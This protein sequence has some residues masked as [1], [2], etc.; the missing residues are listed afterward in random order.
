MKK[1]VSIIVL[2]NM[3]LAAS[4]TAF[5]ESSLINTDEKLNAI[6]ETELPSG[7]KLQDLK[8][9]VE[10]TPVFTDGQLN[11]GS[12]VRYALDS[13]TL[14]DMSAYSSYEIVYESALPATTNY[15]YF[16]FGKYDSIATG[17]DPLAGQ[18]IGRSYTVAISPGNSSNFA[19]Y[20]FYK[21]V[22]VTTDTELSKKLSTDSVKYTLK[23]DLTKTENNISFYMDDELLFMDSDETPVTLGYVALKTN[24]AKANVKS[25]KLIG[26]KDYGIKYEI[27]GAGTTQMGAGQISAKL[28]KAVISGKTP[29]VFALYKADGTLANAKVVKDDELVSDAIDLFNSDS[30]QNTLRAFIWDSLDSMKPQITDMGNGLIPG[31]GE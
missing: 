27:N 21:K 25:I 5:A 3:I 14:Y 26:Y 12:D 23:V 20:K 16:I 7:F 30:D 31:G 8:N 10:K 24:Y 28:P 17:N 13:S 29:V 15:T 9:S 4:A 22:N 6:F 11:I 2:I 18:S 19:K 1:I